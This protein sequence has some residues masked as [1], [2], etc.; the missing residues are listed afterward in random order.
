MFK[1]QLSIFPVML[2][3]T[4]NTSL[5]WSDQGYYRNNDGYS[6]QFKHHYS[7]SM[8]IEKGMNDKGYV[9]R[10]Y[11]GGNLKA[12]DIAAK[13]ELGRLRLESVRGHQDSWQD[14]TGPAYGYF[15]SSSTSSFSRSI[16]LPRDA[17]VNSMATRIVDGVLVIELPKMTPHYRIPPIR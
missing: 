17:D 8:R 14:D 4:V 5:A 7:N 12:E 3:L 10:V 6:Y 1:T 16:R 2:L 9:V 15:R 11:P 13:A